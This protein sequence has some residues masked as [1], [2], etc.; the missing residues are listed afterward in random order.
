M[1][2]FNIH[3]IHTFSPAALGD[4]AAFFLG[5][6][7]ALGE[8]L[9]LGAAF[10]LGDSALGEAAALGEA[11][12]ALAALGAAFL[13]SLGAFFSTAILKLYHEKKG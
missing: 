3:V 9:A 13:V 8:A 10:F 1:S 5:D 7:L 6:A 2:R 4:A 11:L 12:A